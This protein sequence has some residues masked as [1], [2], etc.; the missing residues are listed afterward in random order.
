M[1]S[2]FCILQNFCD[3]QSKLQSEILVNSYRLQISAKSAR[4]PRS[5]REGRAWLSGD[6]PAGL[7]IALLLGK[8]AAAVFLH[9]E[10]ELPRAL[11]AVAEHGAEVLIVKLDTV[12]LRRAVAD[13]CASAH[14]SDR[15]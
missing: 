11:L 12:F 9:V 6:D 13:V 1:Q 10:A 7:L 3:M 15:G 2:F 8:D 14:A 5:V 4:P